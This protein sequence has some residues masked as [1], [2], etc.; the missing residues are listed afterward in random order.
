MVLA[1]IE[2]RIL[3]SAKIAR[4]NLTFDKFEQAWRRASGNE[5]LGI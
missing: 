5:E 1:F 3:T 4:G 2:W